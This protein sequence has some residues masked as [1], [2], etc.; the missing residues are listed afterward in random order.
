MP[1]D[2]RRVTSR[3]AHIDDWTELTPS[4]RR[5]AAHRSTAFDTTFWTISEHR[6]RS[7][8]VVKE[9]EKFLFE[10]GAEVIE[11]HSRRRDARPAVVVV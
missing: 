3:S 8:L 4:E 9:T 11:Q 10:D 2:A 7:T 5:N 1:N 6:V